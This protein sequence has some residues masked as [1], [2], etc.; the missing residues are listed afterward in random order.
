MY[1]RL[2]FLLVSM[3]FMRCGALI[4]Q[5][6]FPQVWKGKIQEGKNTYEYT[7]NLKSKIKDSVF[8]TSISKS[9]GFYCET[10]FRGAV[11]NSGY[12]IVETQVIKMNYKGNND[13]CLMDLRLV[14]LGKKM[15]GNFESNNAQKKECGFGT[16]TMNRADPIIN[17]DNPPTTSIIRPSV[18]A[19]VETSQENKSITPIA[20]TSP[21]TLS[22]KRELEKREE[23]VIDRLQFTEDSVTIT[24][25]DNGVIDEDFISLVVNDQIIFDK[26]KLS[27]TPLVYTLKRKEGNRYSIAFHAETLG[28]IPPNTGLIILTAGEKRK[29]LLFTSDLEKT[30]TI[31]IEL[32]KK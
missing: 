31:L 23:K 15:S 4:A 7:L 12:H 22:N 11:T 17:K 30:A 8:G 9:Q 6:D 14:R 2:L 26:V 28:T 1:N 27:A 32:V 3:L 19:Q 16:V 20:T 5:G 29:E 21:L 24:I 18:I 13:V 10:A 25:Y